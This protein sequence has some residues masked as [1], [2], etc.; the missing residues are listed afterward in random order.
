M[1][2]GRILKEPDEMI[3]GLA[4]F[5]LER[6]RAAREEAFR[7]KRGIVEVLEQQA[8]LPQ[9]VFVSTLATTFNYLCLSK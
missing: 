3:D 7:T 1:T 4:S 9:P 2:P 6:I 8:G 5:P